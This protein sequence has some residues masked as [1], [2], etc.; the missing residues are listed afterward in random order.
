[1]RRKS[2]A[3]YLL[4]ILT[5]SGVLRFTDLGSNLPGLYNDELYFLLSAYAQLFHIGY[6]TVPGYNL[7]DFIFY[8][9]NGYIPGIILFHLNSFSAR[10]PIAFYGTIMVFPVYLLSDEILKNKRVALIASFLWAISPSSVVTSRVGYGVEIFPLFLFMFFIFFWLRYLNASLT[11]YLIY[12][13][14]IFALIIYFPTTRI[15]ASI[16]LIC[17]IIYTLVPKIIARLRKS[18][19]KPSHPVY[20]IVSFFAT[21][22]IIWLGI[23]FLSSGFSKFGFSDTLAGIPAGFILVNHPFPNSLLEFFVRLFYALAPW[24]MFWLTEFN[25]IGLNY[26]SPVFVP[27]MFAFTIPFFYGAIVGIPLFY[28]KNYKVL[29][30][31]A[32]LVGLMLFGIIQP[33]LNGTN[34]PSGFEPSEGIFALPFYSIVVAFSIYV[35]LKWTKKLLATGQPRNS[36]RTIPNTILTKNGRNRKGLFT[37][38]VIALLLFAGINLANFS[39]DLFIS[40]EVYYQN[41][42]TNLNYMFYGWDHVSEYLVANQLYNETIYYFPGKEGAYNL[43][44]TNNFNYWFYHQNFP[45]Y[46]LYTFSGGK[47]REVKP[48]YSDGLPTFPIK[49]A[50]ILSQNASYPNLLTMKGYDYSILYTVYRANGKSAIEVIQ[51]NGF[52]NASQEV[53]RESAK[54][55]CTTNITYYDTCKVSQLQKI[56]GK[57]TVA[58]KS[59]Y[60]KRSLQ[61]RRYIAF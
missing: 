24:K 3:L 4:G 13:L 61:Q 21:I 29:T 33:V 14:I 55:P 59:P 50:I 34:L 12:S 60:S 10:F 27:S 30:D 17:A 37:L 43:T 44:N 26:G 32:I 31:Y 9:V 22:A 39:S 46:W 15:W 42:S 45:L 5:V 52:V 58:I 18:G 36:E 20:Y 19:S 25:S 16:P 38:L 2:I 51:I 56:S 48:L 53:Q 57:L 35:L 7:M 1:M 41:N 8:T 23:E 28:K 11:R 40:S 54:V 47:I 49:N 6:L